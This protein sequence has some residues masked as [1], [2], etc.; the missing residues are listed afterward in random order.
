MGE[1]GK[2]D[3]AAEK[4]KPNFR[5][6]ILNESESSAAPV[7]MRR[8]T[9]WTIRLPAWN[10]TS[11]LLVHHSKPLDNNFR[12]IT[13]TDTGHPMPGTPKKLTES[14]KDSKRDKNPQTPDTPPTQDTTDNPAS[15]DKTAAAGK[16][17]RRRNNTKQKTSKQAL[18]QKEDA[19][20][21]RKA[22]PQELAKTKKKSKTTAQKDTSEDE[23][24]KGTDR[25]MGT[26][27]MLHKEIIGKCYQTF[28]FR[29]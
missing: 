3:D 1:R 5:K 27:E 15:Q 25:Y 4:T 10:V 29:K 23:Y 19:D 13:D 2:E 8:H 9:S 20:M 16:T 24:D 12:D 7:I 21:K 18:T 22:S 14:G 28:Q 6:Q 26:T 17:K 11:A